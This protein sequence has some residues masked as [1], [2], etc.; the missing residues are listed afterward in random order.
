VSVRERAED[1]DSTRPGR[2]TSHH[3]IPVRVPCMH[4]AG[5]PP[6]CPSAVSTEPTPSTQRA[7]Q[8]PPHAA[9]SLRLVPRRRQRA[10]GRAGHARARVCLLWPWHAAVAI[11]SSRIWDPPTPRVTCAVQWR[12]ED[13]REGVQVQGT[14]PRSPDVFSRLII[15]WVAIVVV[16]VLR[17]LASSFV[18]SAVPAAS[19]S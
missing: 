18:R 9:V 16:V 7:R 10:R 8:K 6:V 1:I 14:C 19:L 3:H 2:P 17:S 5:P 13:S 4:P 11:A 15:C 12:G